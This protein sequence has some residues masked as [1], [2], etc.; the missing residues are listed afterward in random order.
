MEEDTAR[1][2]QL[3]TLAA[4]ALRANS[5]AC[6]KYWSFVATDATTVEPQRHGLHGWSTCVS[7]CIFFLTI[8][9]YSTPIGSLEL[10][11]GSMRTARCADRAL[12][13]F[14]GL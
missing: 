11:S 8:P 12:L 9:Q 13:L 3:D 14:S 2:T 10:Y 1:H 4:T 5:S 7:L 6:A